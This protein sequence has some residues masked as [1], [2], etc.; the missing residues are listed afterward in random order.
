MVY[1]RTPVPQKYNILFSGPLFQHNSVSTVALERMLKTGA[2]VVRWV[3][4]LQGIASGVSKSPFGEGQDLFVMDSVLLC[5]VVP[6]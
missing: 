1:I 3:S 2:K 4:V 5:T 6:V